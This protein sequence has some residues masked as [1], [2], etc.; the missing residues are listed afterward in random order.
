VVDAPAG[1]VVFNPDWGV[2]TGAPTHHKKH[3]H[4]HKKHHHKHKKHHHK[5]K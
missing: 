5:K 2:K 1:G 3:H 4:K